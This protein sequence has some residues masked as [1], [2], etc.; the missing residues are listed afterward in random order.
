MLAKFEGSPRKIGKHVDLTK[1]SWQ[2]S[3]FHQQ[4]TWDLLAII[5]ILNAKQ[6]GF[7]WQEW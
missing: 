4:T 3:R 6:S 7:S 2:T 5:G 1:N